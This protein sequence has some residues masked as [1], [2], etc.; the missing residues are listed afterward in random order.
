[1]KTDIF[2]L[3]LA[4]ENTGAAL[5]IYRGNWLETM[6]VHF[7]LIVLRH[8]RLVEKNVPSDPNGV[9]HVK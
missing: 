9:I 3:E 6:R 8:T 5:P 7:M 1:M 2:G 4:G